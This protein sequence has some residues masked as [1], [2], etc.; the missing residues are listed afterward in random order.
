MTSETSAAAKRWALSSAPTFLLLYIAI[1]I[2]TLFSRFL[3]RTPLLAFYEDDF[4]YYLKVAQN[5]VAHGMSSF[6]GVHLTNGYHPLWEAVITGLYTLVKGQLFFVGLQIITLLAASASYVGAKALFKLLGLEG[7]LADLAALLVSLQGLVLFRGGMEI[8]LTIPLGIWLILFMLRRGESPRRLFAAGFLASLLALSRLDAIFLVFLLLLAKLWASPR[9]LRQAPTFFAGT[10]LFP[11][12]LLFNHLYF[13]SAL[14]VSGRAKQLRLMHF[15]SWR[16]P[17]SLVY[18]LTHTNLIFVWA[19]LLLFVAGCALGYR[20]RRSLSRE[21]LAFLWAL[22]LFP[23]LHLL[24]LSAMS[25]WQLWGWYSYPL[26]F[27]SIAACALLFGKDAPTKAGAVTAGLLVCL[28]SILLLG[29]VV[30]GPRAAASYAVSAR[31]AEF[32]NEHPGTYAMGDRAGAVGYLANQPLI[33]L[34]GLMMDSAYLNRLQASEPLSEVL[35]DYGVTYYVT[36]L[37]VAPAPPGCADLREP[38]QA[39]PS[40][41]VLSG[42]ICAAPIGVFP[43]S[44]ARTTFYVF[45][46]DAVK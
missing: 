14:P 25:D 19:A 1:A 44:A 39:G 8:I 2:A 32:M 27:S 6:D 11:L 23:V 16:G 24:V 40:S 12:Y 20:A 21:R 7:W 42:R 26:V 30:L 4:F 36:W 17:V 13:H 45:P 33:Q 37:N 31:I 3:G 41:Q 15:P 43:D 22:L 46:A 38:S 5:L 29:Y 18:P 9:S 34:E 10:V 28:L 35:H